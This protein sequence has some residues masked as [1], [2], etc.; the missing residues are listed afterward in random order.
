MKRFIT[1]HLS[2]WKPF[3]ALRKPCR[4]HHQTRKLSTSTAPRSIKTMAFSVSI[5]PIGNARRGHWAHMPSCFI[6]TLPPTKT[7]LPLPCP[8]PQ[9]SKKSEW[10]DP[11]TTTSSASF[12]ARASLS[13]RKAKAGSSMKSRSPTRGFNLSARRSSKMKANV[14]Q[15]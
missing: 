6:F 14:R 4:P 3:A 8:L 15:P 2:P 1:Y 7:V 5:T 12:K 9:S 11:P 13:T 10:R